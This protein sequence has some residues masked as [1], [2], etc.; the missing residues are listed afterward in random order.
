MFLLKSMQ[1]DVLAT[2]KAFTGSADQMRKTTIIAIA[3]LG[4][5]TTPAI[6]AAGGELG[7]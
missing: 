1:E 4:L 5:A 3:A 6:E 2:L 7:G